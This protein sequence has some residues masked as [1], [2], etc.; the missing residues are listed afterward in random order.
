MIALAPSSRLRRT[1]W[2]DAVEAHGVTGYTVYN[3]TLLPVTFRGTAE[4]CRHL[5]TA[6]QVWDVACE[7]QV[8]IEGPDADALM[9]RLTPRDLDRVRAD[10]CA[11]VPICDVNGGMLND[12]VALRPAKGVWW[13]SLADS[14]LAYWIEGVAM[15]HGYRVSVS[16]PETQI[17]AVQG[18]YAA[19][20]AAE[21]LGEETRGIPFFGFRWLR[22]R[23]G[24]LLISRSGYSKQG[25]FE[26]YVTDE[27]LAM[28]LWDALFEAGAKHDVRA[29]C[30][31]AAER[32]EGGMLSYGN[33]MTRAD[34]P[35]EAGLAAYV[36]RHDCLG[37]AALRS[38]S[39]RRRIVPIALDG[40]PPVCDREWGLYD[41]ELRAGRIRSAA[42]SDEFQC[43]VAIGMVDIG[44]GPGDRLTC[45]T[46][47][48]AMGAVVRERFWR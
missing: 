44:W 26:I 25:G 40:P 9:Q 33:D 7:R 11:Y 46:Q 21:V 31:N 35:F 24:D 17:L 27:A 16:E 41:G 5:K 28:P 13:I 30:P 15:G 22:F 1:W 29:G 19:D 18:P 43:G 10:K 20:L 6:V 3:K 23:D 2:S 37:G 36:Q 4:D 47:D 48:G 34:T 42:W 45:H 12:P 14:D 32:I 8:R 39:A 38:H